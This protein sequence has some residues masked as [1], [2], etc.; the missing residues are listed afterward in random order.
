MKLCIRC[1]T[2]KTLD[3]FYNRTRLK[4]GKSTYC[5]VC[6]NK[7][8]HDN[9]KKKRKVINKKR[10]E[11]YKNLSSDRKAPYIESSKRRQKLY[12]PKRAA[13]EAKRRAKKSSA[14]PD[15]LTQDHLREIETLYWLAKDLKSV[16]G[17]EYHIDH[18]VPLNN[19]NVCGL[20][21]PWNLQVLPSDI[22]ISKSN[23]LEGIQE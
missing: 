1:N 18:I 10:Y 15:W 22:N 17:Q 6:D 12:G 19:P 20:H 14:T 7:I 16:S 13:T 3:E 11:W 5:K 4:D 21:V 9:Y 8:K 2:K 23:S